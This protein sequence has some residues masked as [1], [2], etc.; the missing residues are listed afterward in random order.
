MSEERKTGRFAEGR[1]KMEHISSKLVNEKR[2]N[3][4]VVCAWHAT[5]GMYV[6]TL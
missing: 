3:E 2:S 6:R 1:E 5:R 4:V